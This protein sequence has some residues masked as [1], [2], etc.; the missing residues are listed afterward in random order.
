MMPLTFFSTVTRLSTARTEADPDG[1]ITIPL[2]K[3]EI[4]QSSIY[5]ALP[6]TNWTP[7]VPAPTTLSIDRPRRVRSIPGVAIATPKEAPATIIAALVPVQSMVIDLEITTW[8]KLAA[9]THLMMP[10]A[11]VASWATTKVAHG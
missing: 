10:P 9:S 8:P 1:W 3:P 2:L 7:N 5:S 4:R 6:S 11:E